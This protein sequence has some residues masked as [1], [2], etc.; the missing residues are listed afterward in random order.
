MESKK[1]TIHD[2]II[3]NLKVFPCGDLDIDLI[4]IRNEVGD[5]SYIARKVFSA[6]LKNNYAKYCSTAIQVF[7]LYQK[8]ADF[9]HGEISDLFICDLLNGLNKFKNIPDS[10]KKHALEEYHKMQNPYDQRVYRSVINEIFDKPEDQRV[11][12]SVAD[13]IPDEPEDRIISG[14][15]VDE[16]PDKPEDQRVSGSISNEI[17]DKPELPLEFYIVVDNLEKELPEYRTKINYDPLLHN[18]ISY[19][20]PMCD[21][22]YK[23]KRV[24]FVITGFDEKEWP[25]DNVEL[26]ILIEQLPVVFAAFY[27]E[28]LDFVIDFY[29]Q[30]MDRTLVFKGTKDDVEITARPFSLHST[31][32]RPHPERVTMNR[33]HLLRMFIKIKD[34]FYN[35]THEVSP[36]LWKDEF[37][38]TWWEEKVE[39]PSKTAR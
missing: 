4:R 7:D 32:W 36:W 23:T 18:E 5:Q 19:F 30:G 28:A 14:S 34:D 11:S 15:V 8:F 1:Y 25:V 37:I 20:D 24:K 10:I 26:S 9:N 2:P 3:K 38:N 31:M 12:G 27:H 29:E 16:I 13:E 39:K 33:P 17:P 22:L 21:D 35:L 6:Y